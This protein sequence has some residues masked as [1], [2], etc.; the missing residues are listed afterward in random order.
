LTQHSS[1]GQRCGRKCLT[2]PCVSKRPVADR[3]GV[4]GS[5]CCFAQSLHTHRWPDERDHLGTQR[6]PVR[7]VR[8]SVVELCPH[9]RL[10]P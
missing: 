10:A 1:C 9:A 6:D 4:A 5:W 7:H 2:Q 3:R 8:L